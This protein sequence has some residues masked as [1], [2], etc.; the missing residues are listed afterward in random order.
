[1]KITKVVL[2]PSKGRDP[3]VKANATVFFDCAFVANGILLREDSIGNLS[4]RFPFAKKVSQRRRFAF[5]PVTTAAR[6]KIEKAVFNEYQ[7]FK[8]E[9]E[10]GKNMRSVT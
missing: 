8:E 9:K 1:M 6:Q 3:S 5:S 10:N 4:L 7:K 2:Y